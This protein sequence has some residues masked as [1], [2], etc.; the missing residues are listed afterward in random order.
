MSR[1]EPDAELVARHCRGDRDAF[2]ILVERHQTR[3]YNLAL[4]MMGN[5]HDAADAAQDAF[6]HALR[7]LSGFRGDSAFTTWMHRVTMNACYDI[8]RK[9]RRQPML[10]L[11][12]DDPDAPIREP[13]PPGPDHSE[14]VSSSLDAQAA[15][16]EI[17]EE[18]RAVLVLADVHD[19]PFQE[20]AQILDIPI[21]T[22]KSRAHRGRLAL[23]RAMGVKR[24][25]REPQ[26]DADTSKDAP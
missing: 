19:L 17:P 15:L 14:E 2:A 9:Q 21:G 1:H 26:E 22:V 3:V 4:R 20:I 11:V 23:A 8:L 16:R 5:P 10:H 12:S 7:K 13:G 24:P 25:E 6:M 18:F